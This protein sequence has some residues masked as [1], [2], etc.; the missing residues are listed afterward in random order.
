MSVDI[1]GAEGMKEGKRG[2]FICRG[3]LPPIVFG[4]PLW[5]LTAAAYRRKSHSRSRRS[6]ENLGTTLVSRLYLS[7]QRF[8]RV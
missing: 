6:F 4:G 1:R 8:C 3:P 2:E 7:S 5:P